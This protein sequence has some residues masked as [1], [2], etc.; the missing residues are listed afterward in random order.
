MTLRNNLLIQVILSITSS[1]K[2]GIN[3]TKEYFH[4][5]L[6]TLYTYFTDSSNMMTS[7]VFSSEVNG[8]DAS[9]V[10]CAEP[11][12]HYEKMSDILDE[13]S[14]DM[15]INNIK[16]ECKTEM[17]HNIFQ[18]TT[19]VYLHSLIVESSEGFLNKMFNSSISYV[20]LK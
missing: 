19:Q 15:K 6:F 13:E 2:L 12:S 11:S 3:K 9:N 16:E 17:N 14:S 8:F 18:N 7:A 1:R 4:H 10:I 20:V 5:Y